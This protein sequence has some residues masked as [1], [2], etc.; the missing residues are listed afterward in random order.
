MIGGEH[1]GKG[2]GAKVYEIFGDEVTA[3]IDQ[4]PVSEQHFIFLHRRKQ[5]KKESSRFCN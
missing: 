1:N 4:S 3:Y 2:R 5:L